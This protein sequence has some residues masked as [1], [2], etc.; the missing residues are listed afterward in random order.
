LFVDVFFSFFLSWKE[1]RKGALG[2]IDGWMEKGQRERE[3]EEKARE[4]RMPCSLARPMLSSLS[5]T[6]SRLVLS[7][8][9]THKQNKH[10]APNTKHS[11]HAL[12]FFKKR[13]KRT[14][15]K[16]KMTFPLPHLP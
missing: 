7:R 3:V 12:S 16:T 15:T 5:R 8:T 10:A 11:K 6:S 9:K 2:G 13:E 1:E 14:T 4:T